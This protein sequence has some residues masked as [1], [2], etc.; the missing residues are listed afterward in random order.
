M[1][2]DHT[3]L[4]IIRAW[5]EQGSPKPLRA[6]I[7]LTTDVAAG[8]GSE[9]TLADVDALPVSPSFLNIKPSRF[10]SIA[11]CANGEFRGLYSY[12]IAKC[13][14]NMLTVCLDR[15]LRQEGIRV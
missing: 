7:R 10:G 11:R 2:P 3:G 12:S 9:M 14:Q 15:E 4:L 1:P 8:F 13:A 6:Q 5:V